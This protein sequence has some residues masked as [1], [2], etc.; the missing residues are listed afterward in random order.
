M[1]DAR[2]RTPV[3]KSL[4]STLLPNCYKP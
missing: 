4:V 1:D 3:L 2:N